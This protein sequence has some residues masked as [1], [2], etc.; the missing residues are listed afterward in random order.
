MNVEDRRH[1]LSPDPLSM[2]RV[3]E[4]ANLLQESLC[5]IRLT[6]EFLRRSAAVLLTLDTKICIHSARVSLLEKR[7]YL[8]S[9]SSCPPTLGRISRIFRVARA[10]LH[11]H[12]LIRGYYR[13]AAEGKSKEVD[14]MQFVKKLD[15]LIFVV[16]GQ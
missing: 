8:T 5:I 3:I 12:L 1:F 6:I 16:L 10:F 14:I 4:F 15:N 7:I 13:R 9:F 11:G 2:A